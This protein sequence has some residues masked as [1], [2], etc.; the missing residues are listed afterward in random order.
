M[1]KR[2]EASNGAE[3]FKLF[4]GFRVPGVNVDAL[5]QSQRRRRSS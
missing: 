5:L 2:T 4:G 1:A 3:F